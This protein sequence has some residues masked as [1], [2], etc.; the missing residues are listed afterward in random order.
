MT[1][2][3]DNAQHAAQHSE[4]LARARAALRGEDGPHVAAAAQRIEQRLAAWVRA[5]TADRTGEMPVVGTP[6]PRGQGR[7]PATSRWSRWVTRGLGLT[8]AAALAFVAWRRI[9]TPAPRSAPGAA[10]VRTY[11]TRIGQQAIVTLDDGTSV[12]LAPESQLRIGRFGEHGR[13][14]E[15]DG[16]AYFDVAHV[17]GAPFVVRT[18]AVETRVLGTTFFVR[19]Y[20]DDATARVTV[21]TGKVAVATRGRQTP[22]TVTA[23]GGADATDS[24]VV[25]TQDPAS[26]RETGWLDGRLVFHDAPT[27]DVLHA[28]HRWY[29]YEFRFA[30]STLARRSLT[31]VIS[32]RSSAEALGAL[33]TY[34]NVDLRFDGR[35]VTLVPRRASRGDP[36]PSRD[37][38]T[39][40]TPPMEVGR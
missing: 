5:E 12:T 6:S 25:A 23:G 29:G 36:R 4:P 39:T 26:D 8:V 3:Q 21:M 27:P 37:I 13:T 9:T 40:L 35:I 11:A 34:L 19:R 10:D 30:D 14:V 24:T 38:P 33:K 32:T 28:L 7:S 16:E 17:D 15:L 31:V 1:E 18:G 20:A 22:L 2:D